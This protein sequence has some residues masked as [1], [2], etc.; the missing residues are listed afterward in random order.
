MSSESNSNNADPDTTKMM[1]FVDLALRKNRY[2]YPTQLNAPKP[3]PPFASVKKLSE[4]NPGFDKLEIST[5]NN[6]CVT[7]TTGVR[8]V[9]FQVL[10]TE[11]A[12][13]QSKFISSFYRQDIRDF[14]VR[15]DLAILDHSSTTNDTLKLETNWEIRDGVLVS[16]MLRRQYQ[17]E[18]QIISIAEVTG[19]V[20]D[21]SIIANVP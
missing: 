20:D 4:E 2:T 1:A 17:H 16:C 13:E 14:M 10:F 3:T 21:V 9:V 7:T 5:I 12:E 8:I 18:E 15:E 6:K 11:G 19:S